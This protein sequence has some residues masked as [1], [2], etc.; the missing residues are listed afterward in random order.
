MLQEEV[1]IF[2]EGFASLRCRRGGREQLSQI[3]PAVDL[4]TLLDTPRTRAHSSHRDRVHQLISPVARGLRA[5]AFMLRAWAAANGSVCTTRAPTGRAMTSWRAA[6]AL[7][8]AATGCVILVAGLRV[9][10]ASQLSPRLQQSVATSP[11]VN[12]SF[13]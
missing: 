9:M 7:S 4:E 6:R 8:N 12:W 13:P 1:E 5:L 10:P 2:S 3:Q 11:R